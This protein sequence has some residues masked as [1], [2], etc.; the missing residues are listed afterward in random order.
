MAGS[1]K[2]CFFP[3]KILYIMNHC[4]SSAFC[5]F[6]VADSFL[7]DLPEPAPPVTAILNM[8]FRLDYILIPIDTII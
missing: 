1:K 6:A 2:V 3:L 4:L 8:I 7:N 5:L